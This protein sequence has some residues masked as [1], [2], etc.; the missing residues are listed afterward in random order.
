M[1]T[2]MTPAPY[3]RTYGCVPACDSAVRSRTVGGAATLA[4]RTDDTSARR[5][6]DTS[7][8]KMAIFVVGADV[9]QS[10]ERYVTKPLRNFGHVHL[11]KLLRR[12]HATTSSISMG[13]GGLQSEPAISK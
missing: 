10:A 8:A 7:L 5:M 2:M 11:D 4:D 12:T 1:S 13:L 9:L 6:M 3:V